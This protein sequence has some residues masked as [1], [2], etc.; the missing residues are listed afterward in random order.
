MHSKNNMPKIYLDMDGVQADFFGAWAEQH[1]VSHWKA[2][3]EKEKEIEELATSSNEEVYKFFRNLAPLP[4]GKNVVRW[5]KAHHIP[6]TV[7]SAP[8]KG[9]YSE[10]SI[11]AKKDW[12]DEHNPD[13]SAEAIFT[14]EKQNYAINEDGSPNILIDDY[15][16]YVQKWQDAGGIAIKHEDEYEMPES[17]YETIHLIKKVYFPKTPVEIAEYKQ[18]WGS[19]LARCVEVHSDKEYDAKQ[20]CSTNLPREVWKMARYTNVYEH[21]FVFEFA[22]DADAFELLFGNY[23]RMINT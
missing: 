1:G 20:W 17:W 11:R 21:T 18:Q 10:A 19:D 8:L 4:G 9:P 15:G 3:Q 23:G 22:P 13:T 5:L 7:L 12:L 14:S 16:V 2:I 6:F